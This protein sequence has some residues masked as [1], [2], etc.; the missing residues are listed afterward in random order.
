MLSLPVVWF[1]PAYRPTA[2]LRLP[3]VL[4]LRARSPKAEFEEPVLLELRARYPTAVLPPAPVVAGFPAPAPT[5]RLFVPV[6]CTNSAPL[7][8]RLPVPRPRGRRSVAPVLFLDHEPLL[9]SSF[10]ETSPARAGGAIAR[11]TP[12]AE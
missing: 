12:R 3:V 9:W 10:T 8:E 11:T 4:S 7:R 6:V 5:N 1:W 2:M